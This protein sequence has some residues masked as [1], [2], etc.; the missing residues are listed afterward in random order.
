MSRMLTIA[1]LNAK[2]SFSISS[3][4]VSSRHTELPT[5]RRQK[6]KML[7]QKSPAPGGTPQVVSQWHPSQS[8]LVGL[9]YECSIT[10]TLKVALAIAYS[11]HR[12]IYHAVRVLI[13]I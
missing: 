12:Q 3:V 2:S 5:A 10:S 13:C 4:V 6:V 8:Q 7:S 1:G 9:L 11:E